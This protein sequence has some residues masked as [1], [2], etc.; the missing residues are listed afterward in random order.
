LIAA[1]AVCGVICFLAARRE[2]AACSASAVATFF[3]FL[4]VLGP[5]HAGYE[6][7]LRYYA[8][9]AIGLAPAIFGFTGNLATA[10]SSRT[11]GVWL[12]L[13]VAAISL[14]PFAPSLKERVE[15]AVVHHSEASYALL[16][17]APD[18]AEYNQRVLYGAER[19]T[20]RAIQAKVPAGE[21]VLA[22]V[23]TPFYLDYQR[24]PIY[25][26][27][28]AGTGNPWA[29]LPAARYLI[30]DY[31][32]YATRPYAEYAEFALD[33]GAGERRN[34]L[35]TMD[36]IRRLEAFMAQG[37]LIYDNGEIRVVRL[38]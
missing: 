1:I 13:L 5:I 2:A 28:S 18:Y 20:I 33:V 30:I 25:D 29:D 14:A 31:N 22:W 38:R 6:H 23:N 17:N 7:S 34:A 21:P 4:Y 19:D 24:N 9:V 16:A 36:L 26:I 37:E 35:R 32:G 3:V 10:F 12:P 11:M 8:P 27:D 15:S